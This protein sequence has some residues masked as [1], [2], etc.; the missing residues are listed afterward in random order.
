M[1]PIKKPHV[2][3]TFVKPGL[4][5]ISS[6]FPFPLIEKQEEEIFFR[7][8]QGNVRRPYRCP[9]AVGGKKKKSPLPAP[10]EEVEC[11]GYFSMFT[12]PKVKHILMHKNAFQLVIP[13]QSMQPHIAAQCVPE[14]HSMQHSCAF[15][16][17]KVEFHRKNK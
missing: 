16:H 12:F 11:L 10:A 13:F 6:M 7:G 3:T 14:K 2:P 8:I 15:M 4:C 17:V 5:I 1:V 9:Q